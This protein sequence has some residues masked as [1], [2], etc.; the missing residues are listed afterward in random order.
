MTTKLRIGG[1]I[2]ALGALLW[3]CAPTSQPGEVAEPT[4]EAG[5]QQAQQQEPAEASEVHW[6]Y[7]GAEGPSA[8]GSLSPE[9]AACKEGRAQSPIDLA[10][11]QML[12][13]P[14]VAFGYTPTAL[15]V[16]NTGHTVQANVAGAGGIDVD[17]VHY[18]LV[19]FH[20]HAPSEHTVDGA[21]ADLEVHLVHKSAEGT[22]AV[23]GVLMRRGAANTAL[24]PVW[25]NLPPQRGETR[26]VASYDPSVLLPADRLTYRYEGS[27]TTPPCTEG[28][29]WL[30][31][32]DGAEIS[33]EQVAAFQ[34]LVGPNNRPVQPLGERL[35]LADASTG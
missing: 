26:T 18:D 5:A 8:W 31:L 17:G 4:T 27:L 20:S 30:V 24:E 10:N 7:E 22:L 33:A 16:V 2:V 13:L 3:A 28:V 35:L 9:F 15:E 34:A 19:Q 32:R 11:A 21:G 12:D 1:V 23:V 25:A 6:T 14:D 29:Q